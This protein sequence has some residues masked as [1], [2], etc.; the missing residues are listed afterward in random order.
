MSES[1]THMRTAQIRQAASMRTL[2]RACICCGFE[3]KVVHE[4]HRY[5]CAQRGL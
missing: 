5:E 1:V 2:I 3:R 4:L